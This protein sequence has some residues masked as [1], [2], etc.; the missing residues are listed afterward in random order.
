MGKCPL[1]PG[2]LIHMA[3][4]IPTCRNYSFCKRQKKFNGKTQ[5]F[6][7]QSSTYSVF[8]VLIRLLILLAALCQLFDP[9]SP[10]WETCK[11]AQ[12]M[13]DEARKGL[14][15][16]VIN[17]GAIGTSCFILGLPL[18]YTQQ[19]FS[20]ALLSSTSWLGLFFPH[21]CLHFLSVLVSV[22]FQ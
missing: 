7:H 10:P 19:P 17:F 15:L 4:L 22:M 8:P 18:E 9:T 13:V 3:H 2:L 5:P 14:A 20:P 21:P 12:I 1:S 11:G 6:I 16:R